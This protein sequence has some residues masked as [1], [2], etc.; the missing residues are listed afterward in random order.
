MDIDHAE[1]CRGCDARLLFWQSYPFVHVGAVEQLPVP[2]SPHVSHV[3]MAVDKVKGSW[4]WTCRP[5]RPSLSMRAA[6]CWFVLM[7]GVKGV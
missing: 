6:V 5:P 1:I 7:S 3:E 2:T 4:T